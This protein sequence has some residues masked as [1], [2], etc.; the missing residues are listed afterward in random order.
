MASISNVRLEIFENRE[1]ALVR[2]SYRVQAT[3]H[4]GPHEQAYREVVELIGV[5]EGVGED[6]QNEVIS[7]ISDGVVVFTTSQA[8]FQRGP[9]KQ[10]PR[11]LLDEDGG[12]IARRDELRARVSLVPLP[13]RTV[14]RES[15][16][17]TRGEPV[18]APNTVVIA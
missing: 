11:S 14:V 2:V 6:G 13:P 12:I 16:L 5:D 3:H 15:N 10:V 9:E 4:D 8:A 17:V 7:V 1:P 18:N